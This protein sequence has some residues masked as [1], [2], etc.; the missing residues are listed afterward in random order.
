M[1][2]FVDAKKDGF[3]ERKI[4]DKR[5]SSIYYMATIV[6]IIMRKALEYPWDNLFEVI[7]IKGRDNGLREMNKERS[8]WS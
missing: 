3:N 7:F 6:T 4:I 8:Q 5:C 1:D 2:T